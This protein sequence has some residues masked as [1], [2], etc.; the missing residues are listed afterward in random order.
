MAAIA[1]KSAAEGET[2]VAKPAADEA[3]ATSG[4]TAAAGSDE[5]IEFDSNALTHYAVIDSPSARAAMERVQVAT[6]WLAAAL[7]MESPNCDKL[8]VALICRRTPASSF[9][10]WSC[11]GWRPTWL[12]QPP[13]RS[14]GWR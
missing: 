12:T 1:D 13:P 3:A 5:D 11:R 4:A 10:T 6:E 9:A 2:A 8:T 7:H 14:T